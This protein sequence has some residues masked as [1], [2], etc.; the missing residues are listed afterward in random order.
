[1]KVQ[2]LVRSM[3]CWKT[4]TRVA[5][6]KCCS[7][8][9]LGLP[10][11]YSST[12]QGSDE[13]KRRWQRSV[14]SICNATKRV[15]TS[16]TTSDCEL[17]EWSRRKTDSESIAPSRIVGCAV[18]VLSQSEKRK[19]DRNVCVWL[20]TRKSRAELTQKSWTVNPEHVR[21]EMA[22]L[23]PSNAAETSLD[24][25]DEDGERLPQ[26]CTA[27]KQWQQSAFTNLTGVPRNP[28][29][30]TEEPMTENRKKYISKSLIQRYGET[31]DSSEC[32]GA[33]SRHVRTSRKS[34]S[35]GPV[36]GSATHPSDC[37]DE[38]RGGGSS[39]VF[40]SKESS[41]D[42]PSGTSDP[43]AVAC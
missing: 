38:G 34:R 17:P 25:T 29:E 2:R 9:M 15:E 7:R 11:G 32:L 1:M 37:W 5:W 36:R 20:R 3:V 27:R 43:V 24:R 13:E 28:R 22:K 16:V 4:L 6:V 40:L 8:E 30:L 10:F 41:C 31:P 18:H 26:R 23:D 35:C 42:S 39:D 19:D 33:S 21:G 14:R 12:Q